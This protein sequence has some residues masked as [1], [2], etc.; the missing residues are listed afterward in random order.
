MQD[1]QKDY[2]FF[3]FFSL[4]Y[5][6]DFLLFHICAK[7]SDKGNERKRKVGSDERRANGK[8]MRYPDMSFGRQKNSIAVPH[9]RQQQSETLSPI[10]YKEKR[11]KK[12]DPTCVFMSG[13]RFDTTVDKPRILFPSFLPCLFSRSVASSSTAARGGGIFKI[14]QPTAARGSVS[15]IYSWTSN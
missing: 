14:R 11:R 7:K 5:R 8:K 15:S 13:Q 2:M 4:V 12:D 1:S 3:V 9:T 6:W 10:F